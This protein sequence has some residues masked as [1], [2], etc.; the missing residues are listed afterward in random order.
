MN[1][2]IVSKN[3]LAKLA[4]LTTMECYGV[5]GLVPIMLT[6]KV[7]SLLGKTDLTKGVNVEIKGK[8]VSFEIFVI[9][10]SELK[11][12]EVAKTI[13]NQVTYKLNK[14]TGIKDINIK[15]V[16]AGVKREE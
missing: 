14:L 6:S 2:I 12:S 15:V 4:A 8:T 16:I 13:I 9:L 1:K 3:A 11:I 7:L 10:Q 5:V